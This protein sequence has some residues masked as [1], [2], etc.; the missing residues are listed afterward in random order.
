MADSQT[1]GETVLIVENNYATREALAALLKQRGY[2]PVTA[3][4]G[5]VA[6]ALLASWVNPDLIILD[7][8]MPV[9]DGWKFLDAV[10]QSPHRSVPVLVMSGVDLTDEWAADHGCAAFLHKPFDETA[11]SAAI[12]RLLKSPDARRDGSREPS[13]KVTN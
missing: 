5:A 10:R 12:G 8:Q 3:R 1:I 6:L 4:D 9:L 11:L 13:A 2:K 7:M